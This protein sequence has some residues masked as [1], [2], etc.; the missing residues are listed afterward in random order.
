M[1]IGVGQRFAQLELQV[2]AAVL[3]RRSV[4]QVM[5]VVRVRRSVTH[6]CSFCP[7][8]SSVLN[9]VVVSLTYI[10]LF[11]PSSFRVA[12]SNPCSDVSNKFVFYSW[13]GNPE[14]DF[15]QKSR[16]WSDP[17][18]YLKYSIH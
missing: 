12:D 15:A 16:V 2:M 14:L 1:V 9:Y 7:P 3:T 6:G 10:L 8:Q 5:A 11:F 17:R 4:T 18:F 13:L